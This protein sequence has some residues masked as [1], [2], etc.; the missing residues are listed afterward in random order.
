MPVNDE[1]IAEE[2]GRGAFAAVRRER[3][4]ATGAEVAV[5]ELRPGRGGPEAEA[6]LAA[7]AKVL[8]GLPAGVGP[9]LLSASGSRL[10]LE[11]VPGRG[12]AGLGAASPEYAAAAAVALAAV[13]KALHGAGFV[14]GDL[15]PA[16]VVL[17][18]DGSAR[19]LDFGLAHRA[20]G[21]PAGAAGGAGTPSYVS[22]EAAAGRFGDPRSDLWSAGAVLYELLT[23]SP[24]FAGPDPAEGLRARA[25]R[26]PE[27]P[28]RLAP[29]VPA[30]LDRLVL[31]LLQPE[32]ARRFPDAAA[33]ERAAREAAAS[34]AR[35]GPRRAPT[36]GTPA[37]AP[38]SA[39][40]RDPAER[41]LEEG[42][43][44]EAREAAEAAL[45][46][47]P[48]SSP[49]RLARLLLLGRAC[50]GEGRFPSAEEALGAL[51]LEA[52]KAGDTAA[53][54]GAHRALGELHLERRDFRRAARNLERAAGAEGREGLRARIGLA[55]ARLEAGDLAGAAGD[56]LHAR[57]VAARLQAPEEGLLV[58]VLEAELRAVRGDPGGALEA[59]GRLLGASRGSGSAVRGRARL[60][61]GRVLRLAGEPGRARRHLAAAAVS[62]RRANARLA[63][64]HAHVL[65]A[66]CAA[67]SARPAEA[68]PGL[69]R[70]RAVLGTVPA[71]AL[72][73]LAAA[74][75]AAAALDAGDASGA[76]AALE[77]GDKAG[78][79][80]ED[81]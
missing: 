78:G 24:P 28:S 57:D 37:Q 55:R 21:A 56:A 5:K 16:H 23:G 35:A 34:I 49:G 17:Q 50:V 51:L 47:L 65:A 79:R 54:A 75:A 76:R 66:A 59:L 11:L 1:S 36:S 18:P 40:E 13:L 31:R 14:H 60:A 41:L 72:R 19:L 64:V 20:G 38:A 81:D 9:A 73:R 63:E 10:V 67:F 43:F 33:F 6:R 15:K 52:E 77:E 12:L 74:A 71:G 44:A 3:D 68:A 53:A 4:P 39:R 30:E 62:F 32:P 46:A 7:E 22:P 69:A 25:A 45:R 48:P 8:R 26:A 29:A 80:P 42:R 2:L 27:P 70:A 58:R 61:A